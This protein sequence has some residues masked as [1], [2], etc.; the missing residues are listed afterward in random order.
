MSAVKQERKERGRRAGTG[1]PRCVRRCGGDGGRRAGCA[2][3]AAETRSESGGGGGGGGRKEQGDGAA[4][5]APGESS[6]GWG[7]CYRSGGLVQ[8][9]CGRCGFT[10][11]R[12]GD[13]RLGGGSCKMALRGRHPF[14][15]QC[16]NTP[17]FPPFSF[18]SPVSGRGEALSGRGSCGLS[19]PA[20]E[21]WPLTRRCRARLAADNGVS[22]AGRACSHGVGVMHGVGV[23]HGVGVALGAPIP[24]W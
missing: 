2:R 20:E 13:P 22:A 10:A 14:P 15:R 1:E 8:A 19:P 4:G 9:A 24:S 17:S 6:H 18:W 3:A 23:V 11:L 7:S 21:R 16:W 5:E 12:R